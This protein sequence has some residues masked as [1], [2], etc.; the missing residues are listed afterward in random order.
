MLAQF[1]G[2][3]SCGFVHNQLYHIHSTCQTLSKPI[4]NTELRKPVICIWTDD[5]KLQCPYSSIEAF[6]RNWRIIHE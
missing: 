1:I 4:F 5:N 2:K 3:T 6:L